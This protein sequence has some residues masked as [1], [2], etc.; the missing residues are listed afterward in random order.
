MQ[1]S[2]QTHVS[3]G[4]AALV[5]V[6]TLLLTAPTFAADVTLNAD[7]AFGE[8]SFNTAGHWDNGLAPSAG[9][10][11]FTADFRVRTPPDGG[12][13][14]FA[15]DSLTVNNTNGY[16]HGLFYK[17]TGNT[18][19]LTINNLILDGGQIATANGSADV[20][21]LD[22]A[23][24]VLSDSEI[25]AKQGPIQIL[26]PI[27]GSA[28]IT[29]PGSDG[30][31]SVLTF[32]SASSTF[33][34]TLV[35][36][37]RFELADGAVFNFT[38]GAAGV[39]NSISGGGASTALNGQFVLDLSGAGTTAG[40]TWTLVSA[41]NISYGAT[42]S[43]AGF[44]E[45]APGIWDGTN[46]WFDAGTGTLSFGEPPI[47]TGTYL[48]SGGDAI[49]ESSF[50]NDG[51]NNWEDGLDPSAGKEYVVSVQYLRSPPDAVSY[52]FQ[53]DSLTLK[54]GGALISKHSGA[55]AL[56]ANWIFDGGF[57][58]SG[59]GDNLLET[60]AG[61]MQVTESG[62][63]IRADQTPYEVS[64]TVSGPGDLS[65]TSG[66][67]VTFT[68]ECIFEI[69]AAGVN[70]QI[71]GSG[72]AVFDGTFTFDLTG[73]ST[74]AGDTWIIADVT[75]QTFDPNGFM[76][77]GFAESGPG[78]W[79]DGTYFFSEG[80]GVL[81]VGQPAGTWDGDVS[82]LWSVA[83]NWSGDAPAHVRRLCQH[84]LVR[85]PVRHRRHAGQRCGRCAAL[86]HQLQL[87]RGGLRARR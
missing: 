87:G 72:N 25:Y 54:T 62:G 48:N 64:A 22:G 18:G 57:I 68:G 75:N 76:V 10:D 80:S 24:T 26:A 53:G 73:A 50:D 4:L 86:G 43:I 13:H 35:N 8:S 31:A 66:L 6:A 65:V 32:L 46:Y 77:T 78:I 49:G 81:S 63:E 42:F 7:D 30:G 16:E 23:I 44:S 69:G 36:N 3:Q 15:G 33:D 39:N 45:I 61:T 27:S 67:T 82:N 5:V 83:A 55:R 70:N 51:A 14:T 41:S 74:T 37:G 20:C 29:N 85:R 71:T 52:T 9:N 17:G 34:G 1:R 59:S 12:S 79:T 58:R 28:T 56:T 47:I 11:Y 21:Q 40:D 19:V 60:L 2:R 84:D 38:I